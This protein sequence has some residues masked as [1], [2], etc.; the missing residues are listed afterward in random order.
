MRRRILIE[1]CQHMG[2]I[3]LEQR[4]GVAVI[5][6]MAPQRRNALDPAMAR[7]LD[8][9]CEAVD[10]DPSIGAAVI[11]G[12]GGHFC[13]GAVRQVLADA[14]QDPAHPDAYAAIGSVYEAF[15]RFGRLAVPTVA[16]VCGAAVGAGINL[17]LAADLRVVAE[18]AR[19]M[20]GFQRIGMH[21][22]GGHFVLL[23]RTGGREATAA[24]ALFGEEVDGRQAQAIG[25]A[26]KAVPTDQVDALAFE[27]AS[28]PAK[29]PELARATVK[30]FRNEVGPPAVSWPVALEAERAAQ[31]W[32]LRRR[33]VAEEAAPSA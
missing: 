3:G 9:V 24:L 13:A 5:S 2:E 27:L 28:R 10:R 29:D 26:W 7:E 32:S 22:G 17:L 8:D 31:M 20:A 12:E 11:R 25:L 14:G 6:L 18:D 16:A 21:P 4:D 23:S 30:S 15:A 19:I 33:T 1:G